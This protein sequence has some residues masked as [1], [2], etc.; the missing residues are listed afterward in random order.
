MLNFDTN[1]RNVIKDMDMQGINSR[2]DI[3]LPKTYGQFG[4][5]V[6]VVDIGE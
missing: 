6:N 1:Y 5:N 3:P 2:F 4:H